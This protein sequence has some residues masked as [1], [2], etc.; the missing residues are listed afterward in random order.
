MGLISVTPSVEP[1]R[2]PLRY[3]WT[4]PQC[5]LCWRRENPTKVP[6]RIVVDKREEERCVTCGKWTWSGI[7]VRIDPMIAP[8]PSLLRVPDAL[9]YDKERW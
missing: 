9:G 6:V 3:R 1:N 7:Y 8:Y 2:D 4:Q 5:T